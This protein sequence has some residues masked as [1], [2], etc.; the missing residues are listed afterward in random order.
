MFPPHNALLS[1]SRHAVY[2]DPLFLKDF[3]QVPFHLIEEQHL[4]RL[5]CTV[6]CL[7]LRTSGCCWQRSGKLLTFSLPTAVRRSDGCVPQFISW[8]K[9][10]SWGRTESIQSLRALCSCKR[11]QCEANDLLYSPFFTSCRVHNI[12]RSVPFSLSTGLHCGW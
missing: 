4:S 8:G 2:L 7:L 3:L 9:R 11:A 12:W 6:F 10:A 1:P 5:Y